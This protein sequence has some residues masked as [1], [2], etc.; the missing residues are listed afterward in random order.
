MKLRQGCRGAWLLAPLIIIDRITKA[1]AIGHLAGGNV[2]TLLPGILS[3]AYVENRGMAFGMAS[4][5]V[6]L[7]I[8][9]TA[10]V[11][12]ILAA[13]LIRHPEEPMLFRTG[14][15]FVMGG[16][17]GN[18]YDRIAY[19]FVVDFIRT[20]F[21]DFPVFNFA[22]IALTFGVIIMVIYFAFFYI[23]EEKKANKLPREDENER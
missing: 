2:K 20:D 5:M 7:L 1:L 22:D 6:W 9:L 4:G 12:A 18:L 14:L 13:Y 16:G 8:I 23:K 19:G 11:L 21:M 10:L 17:I 3:F 15:W